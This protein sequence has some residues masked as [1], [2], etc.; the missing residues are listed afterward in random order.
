MSEISKNV[1]AALNGDKNAFDE[2]YK[3]TSRAVYFTCLSLIQN[4]TDAEDI[5]QEVYIAAFEKLATL[6]DPEKFPAWINR[7]AVNKCKDFLVKKNAHPEQSIDDEGSFGELADENILPEE[8]VENKEKRRLIMDIIRSGLSDA[9]YQTVIMFYF[10]DMSI[11][12]IA[13]VTD[14]PEG[15]VKYRLSTARA[16]IKQGVLDYEHRTDDT[17]YAF[18]G[19]PFLAR[20]LA[21]ESESVAVPLLKTAGAAAAA[22]PQTAAVVSKAGGKTFLGTLKGKIIAGAAAAAVIGGGAAAITIA[23]NN[24]PS[25]SIVQ[26]SSDFDDSESGVGISDN[27][28]DEPDNS[29]VSKPQS[30]ISDTENDSPPV[31]A[32]YEYVDIDGGIR[33]TKY[34]GNDEYLT[35]PAVIDGK[36]VLEIDNARENDFIFYDFEREVTIKEITLPEGLTKIGYV[37]FAYLSELKTVHIPDSVT[38]LGDGAFEGCSSLE[39][40]TLPEGLTE[41]NSTF[42]QCTSLS[43]I[44]I[45]E[46]VE[47]L[48]NTFEDCTALTRITVPE[49]VREIDC[50]FEDC[51]NLKEVTFL[52]TE[53]DDIGFN[54]F[55]GCTSLESIVIPNG[56]EGIL[57]SA[58]GGCTS[59][60]SVTLPDDLE[61]IDLWA[62]EG[63]TSLKE[64]VLP[65]SLGDFSA[66]AFEGCTDIK[67]TFKGRVYRYEDLDDLYLDI[68]NNA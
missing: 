21:A 20:L 31:K 11:A 32:E 46:S 8:Y 64:I 41:L 34:N 2:L 48:F 13:E 1:Q 3:A 27:G 65:D 4:E 63:C 58:F 57:G 19:A 43:E 49:N 55:K 6:N 61:E 9:Q 66:S 51:V 38:S 36:K 54:A 5:T 28:T 47:V 60:K 33:I 23:V 39:N 68:L 62:F 22:A 10:N 7:I 12:E 37:A 45:P 53:L 26:D 52:G 40:I 29:A 50:A 16:K 25:D 42:S 59:L 35:V 56:I 18:V 17:V 15:T 30:D 24:A 44:T 67:I 14:C